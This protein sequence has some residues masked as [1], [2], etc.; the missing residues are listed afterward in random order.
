M[1]SYK[2]LLLSNRAWSQEMQERNAEFFAQQ[3][4]GQKPEILWIGCSDSRVSPDQM[5]QTKPGEI[6]IHRNIANVVHLDD[7]NLMSVVQFAVDV[8]KVKH[9]VLCGHYGCGGIAATLNGAVSGPIEKWLENPADV[10]AAHKE[11]V[12]SAGENDDRVNR[13]VECNVRDQLL[14]L[15]RSDTIRGA[16]ERGQPLLLHGW[17]YD[18]RDGLIKPL[19]ELDKDNYDRSDHP[20]KSVLLQQTD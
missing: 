13:L 18:L 9:V 11:D 7:I 5:T 19:L 15:A 20:P 16:F 4:I 1:K 14:T 3:T 2:E 12:D 17:V 10:Y 6:F 8:L